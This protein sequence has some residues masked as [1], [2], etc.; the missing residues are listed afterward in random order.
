MLPRTD[1]TL[2]ALADG[3]VLLAARLG[4]VFG[5]VEPYELDDEVDTA[6]PV[7]VPA[8]AVLPIRFCAA[9]RTLTLSA[10]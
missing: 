10:R 8:P 6:D 3:D 7:L 5:A 2:T 9:L 4:E 1:G